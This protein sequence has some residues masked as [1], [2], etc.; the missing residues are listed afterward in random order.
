M[1]ARA[2]GA[3]EKIGVVT[4]VGTH[5]RVDIGELAQRQNLADR[6]IAQFV[7]ALGQGS[8][9]GGRFTHAGRHDDC[10]TVV[11]KAYRVGSAH[12]LLIVK[13]LHVHPLAPVVCI[14]LM[15][16]IRDYT[17]VPYWRVWHRSSARDCL[18]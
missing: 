4:D 11:N 16:E 10:I 2:R 14:L 18:S 7:T 6:D 13:G 17:Y 1:T 3:A 5:F 12:P 9:Q 15:C 8:E